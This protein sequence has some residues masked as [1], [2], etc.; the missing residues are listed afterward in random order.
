MMSPKSLLRFTTLFLLT[1]LLPTT[2]AVV[3]SKRV[4][5]SY[6]GH[7]AGPPIPTTPPKHFVHPGI[8]VH[9]KQLDY[10]SH[11]VAAG[12]QPWSSA[13]TSMLN[14]N[15]SSPTRTAKPYVTV[16]CGPTS[17]PNIG[18]YQ[19]R[20]DSM[21]AYTNALAWWITKKR[22]YADKAIHYM[23]AWSGTVQAHNNSNAPLQAA[24]SAANWVRAGEIIRYANSG[25]SQK[26]IKQF[27]DM[28]REVYLPLIV[29]GNTNQ[30]GNWEL[31]MMEASLGTA[32]SF[33]DPSIYEKAMSIFA[34]RVPAYIYLKSDGPYPIAARGMNNTEAA[35]KKY[36]FNQATYPVSGITQE[37]CRDFAHLSYGIAS[38]S[39]IAETSRIQGEDLWK[40]EMGA[41]IKA[42]L[43]LHAPFETEDEEIPKWLCNGTIGR[44]I[45]P[46][47]EPP[48]NALAFRLHQRLPGTAKLVV[49][50]RPAEIGEPNPLF[51]GFE[52]VTNAEIPY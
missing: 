43:E 11:K 41:R 8:F 14:Y 50:Q 20:E 38:M 46:V 40:T 19:E 18:C 9:A 21:A 34:A 45:D 22:R 15:I 16:E 12:A 48:Y 26:G 39:H 7:P 47:V 17:T 33:D 3:L 32:V 36:W 1:S 13:F 23:D 35:I 52:T 37:T 31:V 44:S 10:V 42:A 2:S 28:L 5:N 51:I 24:W 27:E 49:Q 4:P 25:W 29:N 6:H 30:N